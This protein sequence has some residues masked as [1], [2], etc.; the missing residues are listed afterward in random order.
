MDLFGFKRR[1]A[2]RIVAEKA[3]RL[4][5]AQETKKKYQ[6]R[7]ALIDAFLS[8]MDE[9]N[10]E[11]LEFQWSKKKERAEHNNTTCP[12]CGSKNVV[13]HIKRTKGEI[14]GEGHSS[15]FS[16]SSSFLFSHHSQYSSDSHSKI[17]GEIDTLPVNRCNDCGNEWKIEEAVRLDVINDFDDY[18]SS[19][20]NRLRYRLCGYFDLIYDPYDIKEVCNSL[21]EKRDRY[22][23]E[24]GD[25]AFSAY[26]NAPRY[27]IEY[28]L[29]TA[30]DNHYWFNMELVNREIYGEVTGDID[31][32][33]YVMPDETWEVAKKLIKWVGPEKEKN[34]DLE[35]R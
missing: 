5:H 7:K 2:E 19:M 18:Y 24:L 35:N 14:H 13:N 32:Y 8:D 12:K 9:K 22:V 25:W 11:L 15:S 6:E 34:Y 27:M 16:S 29:F 1:K 20:P 26:V 30:I 23:N 4:R 10:H 31:K 28:A 21:E 3:E 17:D 33:S